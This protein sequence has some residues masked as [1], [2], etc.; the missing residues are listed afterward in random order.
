MTDH[1]SHGSDRHPDRTHQDESAAARTGQAPRGHPQPP[2]G[3]CAPSPRPAGE[4]TSRA[5]RPRLGAHTPAPAEGLLGDFLVVLARS[6]VGADPEGGE[7]EPRSSGDP[8][9][10]PVAHLDCLDHDPP[11]QLVDHSSASFRILWA[12]RLC[13]VKSSMNPGLACCE[14]SPP[15]SPKDARERSYSAKGELRVT[16]VTLPR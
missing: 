2:S 9:L 10:P 12:S 8:D 11:D 14:N 6:E 1:S 16:G 13:M 15:D 5:A 3:A 7:S 4:R